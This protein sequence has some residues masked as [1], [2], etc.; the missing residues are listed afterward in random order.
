MAS[1]DIKQLA[2]SPVRQTPLRQLAEVLLIVLVFFIATGDPTPSVNE[3]HYIARLKHF[4]N[5]QWCKG[6]LFL[7]STDTQVVFIWLFGWLTRWLSLSA[8]TWVG[9]AVTWI[10]LAWSWQRLSWRLVPRPLAAVLS[11]ALFLR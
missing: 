5:P 11:A 10:F 1:N 7:E 6:D 9:R 4:W 3:T 2:T 8:T